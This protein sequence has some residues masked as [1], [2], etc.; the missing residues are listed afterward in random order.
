MDK[1]DIE[2]YN[3]Y[4]LPGGPSRPYYL[5]DLQPGNEPVGFVLANGEKITE[6]IHWLPLVTFARRRIDQAEPALCLFEIFQDRP[7]TRDGIL[8]S[9]PPAYSVFKQIDTDGRM[10]I[11]V[12]KFSSFTNPSQIRSTPILAPSDNQWARR[13]VNQYGYRQITF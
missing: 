12:G 7:W 13:V 6:F 11:D 10:V 4:S 1:G 9:T 2:K 3:V 5:S 8:M